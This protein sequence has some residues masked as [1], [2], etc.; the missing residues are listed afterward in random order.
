[1]RLS[2]VEVCLRLLR[3]RGVVIP[4]AGLDVIDVGGTKELSVNGGAKPNPL[5]EY[6]P[7]LVTFDGG[8][9]VDHFQT[10]ADYV[11]DITDDS[12]GLYRTFDIVLC[13]DT[14]EHTS[15]PFRFVEA[16]V[17]LAKPGGWIYI[18]APFQWV[19]HPS[20]QD[21][22][23]FTPEGLT[24]LFWNTMTH[25]VESNWVDSTHVYAIAKAV[26]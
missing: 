2:C 21:Y 13:F 8:F 1:M 18:A 17:D 22:W 19:Y 20:P 24:E 25:K 14:L 10:E 26:A 5:F 7:N 23:R 3:E 16:L 6:F 15:N 12:H 11:G 4:N 9:T